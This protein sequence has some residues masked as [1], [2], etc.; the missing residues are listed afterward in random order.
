[1]FGINESRLVAFTLCRL[2][3]Y[4]VV[5]EDNFLIR[6][7]LLW[8]MTQKNMCATRMKFQPYTFTNFQDEAKG[9]CIYKFIFFNEYHVMK[10]GEKN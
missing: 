5:T 7:P 4:A 8:S 6:H 2:K 9:F 3:Y 1:M 10:L